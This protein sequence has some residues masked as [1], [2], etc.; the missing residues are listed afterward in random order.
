MEWNERFFLLKVSSFYCGNLLQ[1]LLLYSLF[2]SFLFLSFYL[3]LSLSR[4]NESNKRKWEKAVN[5]LKPYCK[6][7]T[8]I[9]I[10]KKFMETTWR[11]EER[12]DFCFGLTFQLKWF[13]KHL[14]I[15]ALES[16][17]FL[18]NSIHSKFLYI[19]D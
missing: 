8:K 12:N 9:N 13:F 3:F 17:C 5:F 18:K 11:N 10:N 15:G 6:P 1:S 2:H 7:T 4:V 16:A 14:K 19:F